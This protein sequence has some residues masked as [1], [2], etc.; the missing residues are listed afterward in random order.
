MN[1][2]FKYFVLL[3]FSCTTHSIISISSQEKMKDYSEKAKIAREFCEKKGLN[4]NYCFLLD[5]Q[6][7]SGK[8]R[9]MV[10]DFKKDTVIYAF[11]VSH[12][13]GS[14][15][16]AADFTKSSASFSNEDGSHLSSLGKYRIGER[17]VSQ[18]GVKTK[19]LLHGYDETNSNALRRAIVFHSW[20][21]VPDDAVFPQGTPEGWGCPAISNNNFKQIDEM[22]KKETVPLLMWMF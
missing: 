21:A 15:P 6:E 17:G 11:P 16:W 10:W 8:N 7:H 12:G 19:Y 20:E 2:F 14:Y 3:L 22:I 4:L 5:M 13:C 18:W 9:F 1:S